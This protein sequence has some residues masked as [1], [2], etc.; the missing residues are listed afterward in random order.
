MGP[1]F[2]DIYPEG[3]GRMTGPS[4]YIMA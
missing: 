2:F 3:P 1:L 4:F